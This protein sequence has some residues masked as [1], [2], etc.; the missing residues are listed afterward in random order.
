MS[1]HNKWTS[2]KNKKGKEDA[3]RGKVFTKIARMIMVAVRESGSDP[4]YNSALKTAIEKAK[5]ENMPNDNIERAIKKAAGDGTSNNFE[6][7]QYEGYGPE[8]TAVIVSCLTDNKNRTASDVR[9]AFDK[10]GGN[11]GQTGSVSFLFERKGL[12][13]IDAEGL[14]EETVMMDALDCG[15]DDF[16]REEE[17]YRLTSAPEDFSAVRDGLLEKGYSFLAA[18]TVYLP[19]T[20]A[21]IEDPTNVNSMVKL[22]EMLEDNDDV[23]SV[24]HNWNVPDDVDL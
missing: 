10:H 6:E 14:E 2:I 23:Q 21:N 5:T 18:D 1:G 22:V 3:K 4:N 20:E 15:A 11:L 7:I 17:I 13:I 12:I 8:G 9:H 19:L 24:Y 16:Q